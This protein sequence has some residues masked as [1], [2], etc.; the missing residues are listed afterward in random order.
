MTGYVDVAIPA[1]AGLVC[2][3][4]PTAMTRSSAP[5]VI[6]RIRKIG[7]LLLGVAA[8]YLVIKLSGH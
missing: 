7:F 6:S 8:L 3:L 5:T 2:V 1:L 4:F